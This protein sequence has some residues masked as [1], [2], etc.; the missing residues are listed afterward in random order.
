MMACEQQTQGALMEQRRAAHALRS[1]NE[2]QNTALAQ[3]YARL[4]KRLP[5]MVLMNGVGQ[6]LAFLLGKSEGK[7]D[8][9]AWRLCADVAEW[10]C[11]AGVYTVGDPAG[12][13]REL[14]SGSRIQYQHA[15]EEVLAL[16]TWLVRFADAFLPSGGG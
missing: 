1:V 15:T 11:S 8:T 13:M 10:L 12:V 3:E 9:A 2:V 5:A 16:S 6:A 4:A 14:T 7:E